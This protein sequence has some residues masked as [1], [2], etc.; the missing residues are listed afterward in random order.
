VPAGGGAPPVVRNPFETIQNIQLVQS[1]VLGILQLFQPPQWG[2]FRSDGFPALLPDAVLAVDFRREWRLSDYPVEEG[3]FETYNKV[4]MPYDNRLSLA[5]DGTL[6]PISIFLSQLDEI[7]ASLDLFV[8]I[9]PQ[10]IYPSVNIIH[11]DYRRESRRGASI[12]VADVWLEQVRSTVTTQFSKSKDADGAT[13]TNGGT[14]QP[15]VATPAQEAASHNPVGDFP[16]TTT[17]VGLA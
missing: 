8:V 2:I 17:G 13:E 3:G 11:Y 12:I 4:A 9:T 15:A 5:C 6:T 1:D 7:S 16:L 10:I 14:T